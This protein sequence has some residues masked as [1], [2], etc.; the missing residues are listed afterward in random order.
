MSQYVARVAEWF[1]CPNVAVLEPGR[2][3]WA[4]LSD[5]LERLGAGGDLVTDAHIAALAIEHQAEL[6]SND[7]DFTRFSGLRLVNPLLRPRG[8]RRMT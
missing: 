5:L 7:A 1:T 3:H 2:R 8:S 6:H 4:I